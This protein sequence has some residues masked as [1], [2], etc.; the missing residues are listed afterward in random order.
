ME[1][2]EQTVGIFSGLRFRK[3][4]LR[5]SSDHLSIEGLP[6]IPL[7][8]IRGCR[9][10]LV[11]SPHVTVEWVDARGKVKRL[12]LYQ[13]PASP[14]KQRSWADV[15]NLPA[16]SQVHDQIGRLAGLDEVVSASGRLL[17]RRRSGVFCPNYHSENENINQSN[18]STCGQSLKL[19]WQHRLIQT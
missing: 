2:P 1:C 13:C 14:M 8:S 19:R 7:T 4:W 12:T 3:R 17:F 16:I 15:R 18:C 10:D 6:K 9:P 11:G 5:L